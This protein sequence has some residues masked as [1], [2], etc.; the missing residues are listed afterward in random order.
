MW[1]VSAW[2]GLGVRCQAS[3]FQT[4][5]LNQR[6]IVWVWGAHRRKEWK[7]DFQSGA[8]DVPSGCFRACKNTV[9]LLN[10]NVQIAVTL[11]EREETT[12]TRG[13]GFTVMTRG[14]KVWAERVWFPYTLPLLAFPLS[15]L[16]N[17]GRKQE[18]PLTKMWYGGVLGGL[19]FQGAGSTLQA[20]LRV[21]YHTP[22]A[23]CSLPIT[24]L[25]HKFV[26]FL[27]SRLLLFFLVQGF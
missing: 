16:G 12:W 3:V 14:L 9:W 13:Q 10:G 23:T 4:Q 21:V 11:I 24:Q 1:R 8:P 26:H 22:T 5:L 19:W 7:R 27:K 18:A 6:R 17:P 15:G 25:W 20:S 2:K